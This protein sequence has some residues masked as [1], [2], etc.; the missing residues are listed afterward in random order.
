MDKLAIDLEDGNHEELKLSLRRFIRVVVHERKC[1]NTNCKLASCQR[2]KQIFLH[3]MHCK[4]SARSCPLCERVITALY[5]HGVYC[6]DTKCVVPGCLTVNPK[7][8]Q[9]RLQLKLRQVQSRIRISSG[10][11]SGVPS[12]S[13]RGVS[14]L[15]NISSFA[16]EDHPHK[17]LKLAIDLEDGNHEELK[18]SLQR[19]I[20]VVVHERKCRNTNCRLAS[21]QR[22]KLIFLHN[23]RCKLSARSCPLCERVITALYYHAVYCEDTKC[24][25]PGCLT[26][27]PKMK[28][29]ITHRHQ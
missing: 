13:A 10:S 24:V 7:A 19:F 15:F 29:L 9:F 20:R 25:V 3:N 14:S 5:Y 22:M 28:Q 12:S 17:M 16:K 23:T 21:C 1:R 26:V 2:M 27:Y 8:K 6:E 18:L 4:L 11:A